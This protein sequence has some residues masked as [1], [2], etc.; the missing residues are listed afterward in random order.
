MVGDLG[1]STRRRP[2]VSTFDQIGETTFTTPSDC[3]LVIVRVVDAPRA[4]VFDAWTDPAQLS[5]WMLG[6]GGWTMPI[7]EI[8]L[9]PGGAWRFG[10]RDADG[11]E[12]EMKGTYREVVRPERVVCT[13][14]WGEGWPESLNT[15]VLSEAD[16]KTTI[17]QT[18]LYPLPEVRDA[19]LETGMAQG[20]AAGFDRLAEYLRTTAHETGAAARA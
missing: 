14:S 20:M 1:L 3:E 2:T 5:R 13:E 16:G 10:W 6:P 19:V 7:R 8:D 15:L 11:A 17:T 4:R 12:M 9:R 18:I